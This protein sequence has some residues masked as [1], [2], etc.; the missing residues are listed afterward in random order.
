MANDDLPLVTLLAVQMDVAPDVD[1]HL[2]R[3]CYELQKRHQFDRDRGASAQA[4]ERLI[5]DEVERI[6]AR[7][8]S[9]EVRK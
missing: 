3:T 2:L 8:G 7:G 9:S 5:E 1:R 4:M 6:V